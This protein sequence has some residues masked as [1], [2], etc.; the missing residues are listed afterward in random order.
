M[1]GNENR[2]QLG[3]LEKSPE[4]ARFEKRPE[5]LPARPSEPENVG[6][7]PTGP[8]HQ[9]LRLGYLPLAYFGNPLFYCLN[10]LFF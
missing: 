2:I 8:A 5:N 1:L 3:I 4:N 10:H 9:K 6:S 7:N